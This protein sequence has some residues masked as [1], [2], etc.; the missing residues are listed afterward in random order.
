VFHK[1]K[2]LKERKKERKKERLGCG[3]LKGRVL[4]G[5]N[6]LFQIKLGF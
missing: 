3:A 1:H 5:N 2:L 4:S 6:N